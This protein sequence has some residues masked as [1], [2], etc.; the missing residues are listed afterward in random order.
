[1]ASA[2]AV[3]VVGNVADIDFH[4]T[5]GSIGTGCSHFGSRFRDS[6]APAESSKSFENFDCLWLVGD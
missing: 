1:L 2:V 6:S 5:L 3:G 4:L